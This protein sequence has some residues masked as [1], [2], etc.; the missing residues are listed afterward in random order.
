M[1]DEGSVT[2]LRIN[3]YVIGTEGNRDVIK[4]NSPSCPKKSLHRMGFLI[5]TL[6]N[7]AQGDSAKIFHFCLWSPII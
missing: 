6:Q 2:L 4:L 7:F 5:Q 3:E 1:R